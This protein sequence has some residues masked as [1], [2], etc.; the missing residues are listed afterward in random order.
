MPAA[1]EQMRM[2]E[3]PKTRFSSVH[4][5]VSSGASSSRRGG[6]CRVRRAYRMPAT[7]ETVVL[8]EDDARDAAS[9]QADKVELGDV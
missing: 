7:H 6:V 5:S 2:R 8:V 4:A 3:G 9:A 1:L